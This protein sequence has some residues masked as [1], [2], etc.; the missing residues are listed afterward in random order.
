MFGKKTKSVTVSDETKVEKSKQTDLP[1]KIGALVASNNKIIA[2]N[3]FLGVVTL[4]A[5]SFAW[6]RADKVDHSRELYY[7]QMFADGTSKVLRTLPNDDLIITKAQ[8]DHDFELYLKHR[9]GQHQGTIRQDYSEASVL[10][11]PELYKKFIGSDEKAGDFNAA[12]KAATVLATKNPDVVDIE[13]KFA[14]H[15]D[16]VEGT[17]NKKQQAVMRSNIYFDRVTRES[18]QLKE[19]NREHLIL[20]L[21]WRLMSR[22]EMEKQDEDWLRANPRGIKI[23]SEDLIIDPSQPVGN[24]E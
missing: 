23:V 15:Y 22:D 7:I 21:Q 11:D 24:K 3:V 16:A 20:R 10:L 12:Q 6:N 14:D 18:V 19:T 2:C 5:I 4:V 13:W 17:F 8:V 9:Y 1:T